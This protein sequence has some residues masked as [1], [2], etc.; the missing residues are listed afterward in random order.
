MCEVRFVRAGATL[1]ATAALTMPASGQVLRLWYEGANDGDEAGYVSALVDPVIGADMSVFLGNSLGADTLGLL[2]LGF[3]DA[4]IPTS[5]GGTLLVTPF[6]TVPLG[7]PADGLTLTETLPDEP[8][9]C[10][11]ELF[12]QAIE[13]D[14][15]ASKGLSFTDGLLLHIGMFERNGG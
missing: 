3:D 8:D 4:S 9:L 10:D 12:L 2:F 14:D 13:L 1:L 6:V 15:G 5:K 11:G 7:I